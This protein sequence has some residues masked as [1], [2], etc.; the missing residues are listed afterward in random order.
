MN[1][2]YKKQINLLAEELKKAEIPFVK[3][4]LYDGWQIAV[5]TK[6][7]RYRLSAVCHGGSYGHFNGLLEIMGGL[8]IAERKE[9]TRVVGYL[10]AD[11]VFKRFKYCYEQDT[12]LYWEVK[13]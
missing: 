4:R 6:S 2:I 13:R 12:D 5:K 9:E 10:Y 1:E 3:R 11:E 7:G 8:T